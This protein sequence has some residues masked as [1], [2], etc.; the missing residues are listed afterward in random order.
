MTPA[1]FDMTTAPNIGEGYFLGDYEGLVAPGK[2]FGAFFAMPSG[3]DMAS[4]FYRDPLP[5]ETGAGGEA[6]SEPAGARAN[7]PYVANLDNVTVLTHPE[8][9]APEPSVWLPVKG[10][11]ATPQV[12]TVT[13]GSA[14]R[15]A[16]LFGDVGES[17]SLS[18]NT[19]KLSSPLAANVVGDMPFDDPSANS[20]I[21][22]TS[23]S[24]DDVFGPFTT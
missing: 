17:I 24:D 15:V 3:S 23:T 6:A 11:S 21:R 19:R 1:S 13:P 12:V 5:A 8:F 20:A 18:P 7:E 10:E 4:I 14:G 2:N 22:G 9:T 16:E